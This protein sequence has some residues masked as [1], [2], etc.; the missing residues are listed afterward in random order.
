LAVADAAVPNGGS[1]GDSTD[2]SNSGAFGIFRGYR[3][4]VFMAGPI[5]LVGIVALA[6]V[7]HPIAGLLVAAGLAAGAWN[8]WRVQQSAPKILASGVINKRSMS[9]SGV[10]RLG[11]LTLLAGACAVAV[12][13]DG[14]TIAIGLAAFQILLLANMVGPLVREVRRG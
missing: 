3:R 14:W 13:P 8:G 12:R 2:G 5:G 11:Y 7:G 4:A 6:L 9:A 1:S 10:R